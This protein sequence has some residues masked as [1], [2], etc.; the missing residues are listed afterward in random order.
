MTWSRTNLLIKAAVEAAGGQAEPLTPEHTDFFMRLVHGDRSVVISKTRSPFLTQIAQ[1]L[2]NNKFV[3]RHLLRATGAPV[4]DNQLLDDAIHAENAESRL[5]NALD[6]HKRLVIKPNWANRGLG[7]T[8]NVSHLSAALRAWNHARAIDLDEE[9][10]VEPH[11]LGTNV[12]LT[13]IG[14]RFAAA[15]EVIRP[16]LVG[17]GSD[18][19]CDLVRQLNSDP[20]RGAWQAPGLQPLDQIATG[21]ELDR[22]LAGYG[23]GS[24]DVLERNRSLTLVCDEQE[25]IDITDEVHTSWKQLAVH[26]CQRI[27]ADVAGVDVR[28]PRAALQEPP[29]P[30]G[31][32][33]ILEINVLPA[34]HMHA[35][36]TQGTAR[37]VFEAFVAYCLSLPNA[38]PPCATVQL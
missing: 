2:A 28:G 22:A 12:R 34:L 10:L 15:C 27:G 30:D 17:N 21:P 38:P 29:H 31:P 4:I 20:R 25:T 1:T 24:G 8:T 19:I 11:W 33:R 13:V 23:L 3:S 35:R 16:K 36:P 5:G 7:V 32:L 37:P 6:R 14:G 18:R 9:V 26:A